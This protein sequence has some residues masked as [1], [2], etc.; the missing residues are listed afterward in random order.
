MN[1]EIEKTKN[2]LEYV[3]N[4]SL[5]YIASKEAFEENEVEIQRL[6]DKLNNLLFDVNYVK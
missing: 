6:T 1:N 4:V 2:E 3:K 5:G